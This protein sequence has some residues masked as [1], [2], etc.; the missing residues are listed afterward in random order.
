MFDE[1]RDEERQQGIARLLRQHPTR[2]LEQRGLC[3]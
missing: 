3:A 1:P 2:L